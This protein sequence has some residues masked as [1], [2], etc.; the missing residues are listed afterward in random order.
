MLR[1]HNDFHDPEEEDT[2]FQIATYAGP[3]PSKGDEGHPLLVIRTNPTSAH[4]LRQIL[5]KVLKALPTEMVS[6]LDGCNAR[7]SCKTWRTA[8]ALLPVLEN[9]KGHV[10]TIEEHFRQSSLQPGHRFTMDC[11]VGSEGKLDIAVV[12]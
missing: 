11:Y 7:L 1:T 3:P 12:V 2:Y 4:A 8:L 10:S 9:G 6:R 5:C